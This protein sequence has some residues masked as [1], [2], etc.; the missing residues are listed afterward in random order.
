LS[1]G[2]VLWPCILVIFFSLKTWVAKFG[3]RLMA[4]Y[5]LWKKSIFVQSETRY[6][7]A[8]MYLAGHLDWWMSKNYF[9]PCFGLPM[10]LLRAQPW[11]CMNHWHKKIFMYMYIHAWQVKWLQL[12]NSTAGEGNTFNKWLPLFDGESWGF[13]VHFWETNT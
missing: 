13:S 5:A 3:M 10:I 4:E 7:R 1:S 6:D 11:P 8:R 9:Q 2:Y 12:N